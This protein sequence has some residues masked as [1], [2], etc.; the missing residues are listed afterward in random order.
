MMED[1][2]DLAAQKFRCSA[3][4]RAAFEAGIKMGTIYHQF[5]GT[6]VNKESVRALE[7]SMEKS[8]LV[9]PY[10]DRVSVT[11]DRGLIGQGDDIYSYR[12]LTGE[13]MD[14]ELVIKVEDVSLRAE[15][16]YDPDL[17]YPLMYI[18]D[19]NNV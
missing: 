1:K 19:V 16:H 14:I 3:R 13:M 17:K 15:M 18:S 8:I 12:S 11:I 2:Q 4:E 10:V 7:V 6:P 5:V 9:Q